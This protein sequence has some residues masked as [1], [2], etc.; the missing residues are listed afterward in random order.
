MES[1][2]LSRKRGNKMVSIQL[3]LTRDELQSLVGLLDAGL[4]AT[5]LRA[6]K[7]AAMLLDKIEA[8]MQKEPAHD[9]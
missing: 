4:R 8:A 6:A 7:D 5:G 2:I 9:E 3:I 1:V